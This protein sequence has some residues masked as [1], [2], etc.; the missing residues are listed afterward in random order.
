[1]VEDFQLEFEWGY[2]EFVEGLGRHGADIVD[3]LCW[4]SEVMLR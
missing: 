4:K 3:L 2:R 1:M